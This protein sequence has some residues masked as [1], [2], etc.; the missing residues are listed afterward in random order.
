VGGVGGIP[1]ADYKYEVEFE[2]VG[3]LDKIVDRVLSLLSF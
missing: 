1:P 2:F 3:L